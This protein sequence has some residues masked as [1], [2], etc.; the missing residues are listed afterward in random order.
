MTLQERVT[1]LVQEKQQAIARIN[2]INGAIIELQSIEQE[3]SSSPEEDS[4]VNEE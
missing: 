2:Q 1:R 4:P 3:A